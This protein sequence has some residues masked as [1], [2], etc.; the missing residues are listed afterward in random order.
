MQSAI[1]A[2]GRQL[3]LAA[4]AARPQ[5]AA[6]AASTSRR[7]LATVAN[8]PFA[9][10]DPNPSTRARTPRPPREVDTTMPLPNNRAIVI[11]RPGQL[12]R[13]T[14]P[15]P[16]YSRHSSRIRG[17]GPQ[18][19]PRYIE[20]A[21]R[22]EALVDL[23]LP[24]VFVRLVRN[25]EEYADDPFTA[26]FRTS[27][28]LTK[29]DIVNYLRNIYGLEVTSVRT[30]NYLGPLKRS[31]RGGT[32][33]D[34]KK[35]YKKVLV[36]LKEPFWYPEEPTRGWLNEHFERDRMEEL[37]DRK[38]LELGGEKGW[39]R[40]SHRYRGAD[41]P[42]V[43]QERAR[44]V[45]VNGGHDVE[46]REPGDNVSERKPTGLKRRKNVRRAMGEKLDAK[47]ETI[48]EQVERLRQQGW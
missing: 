21:T 38:M 18:R 22:D 8:A 43:E 17:R 34:S 36:T 12:N 30:M 13:P 28:Q 25:T 6:A 41:K 1:R 7:A 33:R 3:A 11:P 32:V 9:D 29:P 20:Q 42:K 5:P 15:S 27:L 31:P 37:R 44:L 35:T 39:G 46:Y 24:S 2:A 4:A 16:R 19:A 10:F 26:T 48:D 14:E 47:I 40:Q 23:Y 45:S